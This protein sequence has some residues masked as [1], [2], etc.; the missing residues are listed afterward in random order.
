MVIKDS[1]KLK[2]FSLSLVFISV[3]ISNLESQLMTLIM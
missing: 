3:I 1:G 2:F